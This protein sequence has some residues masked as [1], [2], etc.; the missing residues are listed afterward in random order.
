LNPPT[1][2]VELS[3]VLLQHVLALGEESKCHPIMTTT[4]FSRLLG[5]LL[6]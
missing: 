4:E 5:E 2:K 3:H 6:S 1:Q